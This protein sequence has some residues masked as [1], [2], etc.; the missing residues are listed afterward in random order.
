MRQKSGKADFLQ[1]S[2][3]TYRSASY[4]QAQ[5]IDSFG[6][7]EAERADGH[8]KT[9]GIFADGAWV[10]KGMKSLWQDS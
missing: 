6:A 9:V 7:H 1:I 3:K 8:K 4:R 2:I 10:S 5:K